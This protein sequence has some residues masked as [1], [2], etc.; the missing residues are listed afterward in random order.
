MGKH[1]KLSISEK[2][3]FVLEAIAICDR[4]ERIKFLVSKAPDD[5]A[6]KQFPL[7]KLYDWIK[8]ITNDSEGRG[9]TYGSVIDNKLAEQ[10]R[11]K[12]TAGEH[13]NLDIL[14]TM[15]ITLCL[16]HNVNKEICEGKLYAGGWAQGF[17]K[18][19]KFT[20]STI[21]ST[22]STQFAKNG[23]NSLRYD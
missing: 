4:A 21:C 1:T 22:Q 15:L 18:R 10:V 12:L 2:K 16:D 13:V 9:C 20:P 3:T 8:A 14:R 5:F 23:D 17:A 6:H 7:K 11:D 19:H